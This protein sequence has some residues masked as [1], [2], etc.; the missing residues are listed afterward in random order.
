MV[1]LCH[2]RA[3]VELE[4]YGR[5]L[6]KGCACYYRQPIIFLWSIGEDGGLAAFTISQEKVFAQLYDKYGL[7]ACEAWE[8]CHVD[9][10]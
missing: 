7:R 6:L 1:T 9:R 8:D 2:A 3:S 4:V 10:R 5:M